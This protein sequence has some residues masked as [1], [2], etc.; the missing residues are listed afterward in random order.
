MHISYFNIRTFKI[1]SPL[2]AGLQ[3]IQFTALLYI[4]IGLPKQ[5]SMT[6][7][8][9][10][11]EKNFF[12]QQHDRNSRQNTDIDQ[13]GQVNKVQIYNIDSNRHV[14]ITVQTY[15]IIKHVAFL[16]ADYRECNQLTIGLWLTWSGWCEL[17]VAIHT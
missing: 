1:N 9:T 13:L 10:K 3:G 15:N 2:N 6:Q 5:V 7:S 17:N 12:L 8:P 11:N 16:S 14:F 4:G